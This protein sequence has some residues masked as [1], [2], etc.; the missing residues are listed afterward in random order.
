MTPRSRYA[1]RLRHGRRIGVRLRVSACPPAAERAPVETPGNLA[2]ERYLQPWDGEGKTCCGGTVFVL[3][4]HPWPPKQAHWCE[5]SCQCLRE[6]LRTRRT[7]S[8]GDN[9]CDPTVKDTCRLGMRRPRS[10]AKEQRLPCHCFE[11]FCASSGRMGRGATDSTDV[12]WVLQL[13][14]RPVNQTPCMSQETQQGEDSD[15]ESCIQATQAAFEDARDA[16]P[17]LI[18]V[19][20]AGSQS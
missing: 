20:T 11:L 8:A 12:P 6:S 19:G 16:L 1:R 3:Q 10:K 7:A 2:S 17:A 13:S 18:H 15:N 14:D 9:H 4:H 5:T